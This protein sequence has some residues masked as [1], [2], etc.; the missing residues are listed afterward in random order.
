[1]QLIS[2]R[3]PR[4]HEIRKAARTGRPT[5]AGLIVAEGPHLLTEAID[6][7]WSLEQVLCTPE[8]LDQFA[9]ILNKA[10]APVMEVSAQAF[11]SLSTTE[12]TQGVLSLLRPRR[13]T[14]DDMIRRRPALTVVLESIQDPG[15]V[16]TII[17]SAEAF[18]ATGILLADGCSR[19]S[20]GKLLRAA[21]GS[22]FRLPFLE[23]LTAA[24]I[25]VGLGSADLKIFA[26]TSA[27]TSALTAIDLRSPCALLVGN[28]GSGLSSAL[29]SNTETVKIPVVRVESLNAAV[30]CS[31]ALFEAA[32]QRNAS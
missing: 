32:R 7:F 14:W 10:S 21:A 19:V 15:N 28:E 27:G 24:K 18:G 17:R 29:L 16:G 22:I 26:L 3:N 2:R 13:W 6:S 12:S 8:A 31:V 30:A 4:I 25:R 11:A 23:Q 1:M 5:P 20:N 9:P